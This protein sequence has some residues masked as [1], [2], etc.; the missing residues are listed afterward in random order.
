MVRK[1]LMEQGG[2]SG[3]HTGLLRIKQGQF[4]N[5]SIMF[6][7]GTTACIGPMSSV[8]SCLPEDMP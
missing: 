4:H 8:I 2:V 6:C 3:E 5:S 1:R 7:A